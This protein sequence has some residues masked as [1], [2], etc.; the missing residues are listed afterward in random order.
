M[1]PHTSSDVQQADEARESSDAQQGDETEGNL[2]SFSIRDVA[3][4]VESAVSDEWGV[5]LDA[6]LPL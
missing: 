3:A 4:L 2:A 1:A 5:D 6:P